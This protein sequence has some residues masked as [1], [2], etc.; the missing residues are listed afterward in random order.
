MKWRTRNADHSATLANELGGYFV[1]D[2]ATMMQV[3][4]W[5]YS[6]AYAT[7]AQ[8]WMGRKQVMPLAA[9]YHDILS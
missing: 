9:D 8:S 1:C 5:S 4:Q 6:N 3:A 7:A 2:E